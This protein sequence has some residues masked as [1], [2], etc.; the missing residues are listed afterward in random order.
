MGN[1][2]LSNRS[3]GVRRIVII[4]DVLAFFGSYIGFIYSRNYVSRPDYL[5]AF[6]IGLLGAAAVWII[7]VIVYWIKDGFEKNKGA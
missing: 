1:G 3:K 6:F 2:F 5:Y 7:Y 4:L